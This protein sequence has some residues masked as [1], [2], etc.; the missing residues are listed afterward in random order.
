M[1][2]YIITYFIFICTFLILVMIFRYFGSVENL[3]LSEV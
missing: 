1:E 3:A 2:D